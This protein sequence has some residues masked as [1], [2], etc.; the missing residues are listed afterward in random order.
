MTLE[1]VL[2]NQS[3]PLLFFITLIIVVASRC[4]KDSTLPRNNYLM[5]IMTKLKR[6]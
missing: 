5:Y 4:L 1:P 2:A 3:L 6:C